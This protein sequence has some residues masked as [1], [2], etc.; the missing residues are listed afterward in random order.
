MKT[1]VVIL[2][3]VAVTNAW[4]SPKPTKPSWS[5]LYVTFRTFSKL[6]TEK[7]QAV[8]DGWKLTKAC[9]A[10]NYFQ[11]NRYVLNGDTAVMLLFG[12]NGQVAGIQMGVPR[13][14]VGVKR[15]PWIREGS[16]YV[17]TA[18]FRDPSTICSRTMTSSSYGD[19]LV[20]L[21]GAS[22]ATIEIPFKEEGLRGTKW[23]RGHCFPWMGQ[24]YWYNISANMRCQDFFPVFIMYNRKRLD[25]FG[26]NTN[27][28]LKSKRFE[29]PPKKRLGLFFRQ[30]TMPTCLMTAGPLTTQHVYMRW[31]YTSL[32]FP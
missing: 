24:H 9:D 20:I 16:M 11:G 6:P 31:P 12:A 7:N 28:D 4:F 22:N 19:R 18:Y 2:L 29:H 14:K 5:K 32:C 17:M 10:N 25:G 27:G 21:N 23:V 15:A 3:F 8:K 1:L 30:E 13:S 26:W